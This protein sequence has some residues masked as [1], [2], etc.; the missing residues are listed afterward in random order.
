MEG[1]FIQAEKKYRK[2]LGIKPDEAGPY[3]NLARVL[4]KQEKYTEIEKPL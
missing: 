1:N 2:A 4:I 3:L